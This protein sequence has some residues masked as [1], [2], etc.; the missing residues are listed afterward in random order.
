MESRLPSCAGGREEKPRETPRAHRESFGARGFG[1]SIQGRWQKV[2]GAV[3]ALFLSLS[4]PQ[5]GQRLIQE[6]PEL[7]ETVRKKLGEIRQCWAE[8][9]SATQAK[10]QQLLEATQADRI[11]QSYTELDKQLLHMESQLQ[12]VDAGPDLASVNS[13]LKKLQ[14]GCKSSAKGL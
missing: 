7:A 9:E 8:L 1:P 12:A 11:V 10:A 2:W 13:N 5:E 6:K 4:R 14:V 3:P